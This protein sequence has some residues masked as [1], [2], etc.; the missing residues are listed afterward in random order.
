MLYNIYRISHNQYKELN[1]IGSCKDL[2]NRKGCHKSVCYTE[3]CHQFNYKLY[4]FIRNNNIDFDT[5]D[6]TVLK[7]TKMNEPKRLEQWYI[8]KFNSIQNGLNDRNSYLSPKQKREYYNQNK[9]QMKE[10]NKEYR[11]VNR[12][13][14]KEYGK[15]YC[16]IP[17]TCIICNKTLT[18]GNK[19]RHIRTIKHQ[20]N[21]I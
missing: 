6:F 9:E 20:N 18:Q 14:L 17:W 3:N 2:D 10:R 11:E 13:Q 5:L 21:L 4:Q 8:N 1:Y 16:K 15:E 19:A 7:K 12:D